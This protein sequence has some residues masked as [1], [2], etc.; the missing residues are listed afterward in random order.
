MSFSSYV[1]FWMV[2]SGLFIF[3]T[4]YKH[5]LLMLLSLEVV[6]LSLYALMFIFMSQSMSSYFISMFYLSMS[7]CEG[8]LGL[9]LLVLVIRVYGVD[10][11]MLFDNLW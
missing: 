6:V 2:F 11:L 1:F 7:V 5:F 10:M 8:A 9:S 4:K 3:I